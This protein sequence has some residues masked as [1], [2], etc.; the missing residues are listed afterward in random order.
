MLNKRTLIGSSI[1]PIRFA[2]FMWLIFAL[3]FVYGLEIGNFGLIPRTIIGS[4]GIITSPF[5]HSDPI[6]LIS[7]T[8]PFLFLGV[9][10]F[11]YY[12]DKAKKVFL[13][14]Y[15]LTNV[16][17]WLFA[18]QETHIGASGIVY[19]LA[20][21]LIAY[22]LVKREKQSLFISMVTLLLY[23]SIYSGLLSLEEG[24]SWESHLIGALVGLGLAL[25]FVQRNKT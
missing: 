20:T 13:G 10:L 15:I 2:F 18:R 6:H 25:F 16:L 5:F 4:I 24:V 3:Q 17:V 21:F 19:A 8:I 23:G 14:C 22:G 12:P 7:N 1:I 9:T 11:F